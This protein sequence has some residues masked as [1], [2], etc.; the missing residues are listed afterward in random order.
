[1]SNPEQG[2]NDPGRT[3]TERGLRVGA[4]KLKA[5]QQGNQAQ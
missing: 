2:V 3:G 1:M 4:Q 5:K